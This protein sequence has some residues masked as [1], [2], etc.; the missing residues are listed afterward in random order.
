MGTTLGSVV[1]GF[2][3]AIA[4]MGNVLLAGSFVLGTYLI[5]SGVHRLKNGTDHGHGRDG[6]S[7]ALMRIGG[8]S[9]LTSLLAFLG[10]GAESI[11]G[12][13]AGL[14]LQ[15]V[16]TGGRMADCMS[17]GG[18]VPLTCVAQNI[19]TDLVPVFLAVSFWL[20]YMIGAWWAGSAVHSIA[21]ASGN[22]QMPRGW[23]W[24][25]GLG[26]LSLNTPH[27]MEMFQETFG[28]SGGVIVKSGLNSG[29]SLL[30][31]AAS[32][33]AALLTQYQELIKW[34]FYILVMFGVIAVL[35][36][37][38]LLKAHAEGSGQGTMGAGMTHIVGGVLLANG[39][40][41][42]CAVMATFVGNGLGF[43]A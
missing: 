13:D 3:D 22:G 12:T 9:V 41:T 40:F 6:L 36:G 19:A 5:A 15:Q 24:K 23:A 16:S 38:S 26:V 17:G 32:G 28:I 29:S 2:G 21:Q 4:P 7:D 18:S 42:V 31:Y 30:S 1:A 25:M 35:R 27:L 37:I 33:N 34:V 8:G 10:V 11:Y 14:V 43:C 20:F 39:K